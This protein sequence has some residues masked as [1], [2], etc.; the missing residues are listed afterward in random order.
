M[1]RTFTVVEILG[2]PF[3]M[4]AA[5]LGN[6][7]VLWGVLTWLG[8]YWHPERT[9]LESTLIG[10]GS[11]STLFIADFGHAIAHIFSARYSGAPMDEIIISAGMPRTLYR[12]NE[13]LPSIHRKRAIGGPIFS[14]AGLMLS[15]SLY[16]LM[17]VGSLARE[18]AGWSSVGHGFILV[19]SLLPLPFVDGGTILKWTLVERGYSPQ[20]AD[21][22]LQR[23]DVALGLIAAV[24]AL[25]LFTA[26]RWVW[27]LVLVGVGVIAIGA[28]LGKIR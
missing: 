26:Q 7:V 19:G 8:R 20:Q 13:V 10:F 14:L 22:A 17:P 9:W 15:L 5:V 28:G 27:G 18:L 11:M 23:I 6:I 4:N 24:G 21:A 16:A 12:N 25:I 1:K 3:R 2:T